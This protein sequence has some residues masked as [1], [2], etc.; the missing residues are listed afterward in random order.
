[1]A[2]RQVFLVVAIVVGTLNITACGSA[3][4]PEDDIQRLTREHQRKVRVHEAVSTVRRGERIPWVTGCE[5]ADDLRVKLV[6]D[7]PNGLVY[8]TVTLEAVE[9]LEQECC[10]ADTTADCPRGWGRHGRCNPGR[11]SPDAE[12]RP[13][14]FEGGAS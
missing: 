13:R 7:F 11:A 6:D 10:A 12:C 2:M 1:M 8:E 4:P 3:S 5:P 9:K 14:L